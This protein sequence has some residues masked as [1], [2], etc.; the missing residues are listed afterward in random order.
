MSALGER[1]VVRRDRGRLKD[2]HGQCRGCL[3]RRFGGMSETVEP[4]P[5]E[6]DSPRVCFSLLFAHVTSL[7]N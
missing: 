4:A 5:T 3:G 1:L 6:P 7:P 2:A